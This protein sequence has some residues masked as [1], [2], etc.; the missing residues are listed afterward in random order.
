VG[1]GTPTVLGHHDRH[2]GER[3]GRHFGRVG[4]NSLA[5]A[6]ESSA[7]YSRVAERPLQASRDGCSH[8]DDESR[9]VVPSAA[10]RWRP[11]GFA[12]SLGDPAVA[13][14]S[15]HHPSDARTFAI[16]SR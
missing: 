1:S 6:F 5:E 15:Y 7:S 8:G 13:R 9:A 11:D 10:L 4:N 16:A 3:P 12:G 2:A 14:K